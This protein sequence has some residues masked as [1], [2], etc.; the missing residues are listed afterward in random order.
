MKQRNR[1]IIQTVL[2]VIGVFAII[3]G[4]TI[5]VPDNVRQIYGLPL[6]WGEH[7][8]VSITGPVDIWNINIMYLLFD[9]SFWIL[10]VIIAPAII[11]HFT[12]ISCETCERSEITGL[13]T[14]RKPKK[15]RYKTSIS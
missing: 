9:V 2:G 10:L 14:K 6:I 12:I 11:D 1:Y 5:S 3:F 7:Q 13:R 8:I 15:C 4:R